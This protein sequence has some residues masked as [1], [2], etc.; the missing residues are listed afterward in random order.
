MS[1]MVSPKT[2]STSSRVTPWRIQARVAAEDLELGD[3]AA[4]VAQQVGGQAGQLPVGVVD[5]G[6]AAGAGVGPADVV[7]DAQTVGDLAGGAA[8]V[9]RLAAGP[10]RGCLLQRLVESRSGAASRP[11]RSRRCRRRR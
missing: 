6:Q 9:D 5:V 11:A 1:V 2:Y 3:R 4:G 7:E 10:Q 8:Q